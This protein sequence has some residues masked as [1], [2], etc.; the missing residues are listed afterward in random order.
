ML[1]EKFQADD[2]GR[3]ES[4]LSTLDLLC[5][6]IAEAAPPSFCIFPEDDLPLPFYPCALRIPRL[7]RH[8]L[9]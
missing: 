4:A 2:W 7:I 1:P 8:V 3:A 9:A 6:E 5:V